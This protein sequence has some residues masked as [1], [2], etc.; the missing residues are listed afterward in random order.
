MKINLVVVV[1]HTGGVGVG[2]DGEGT[3]GV[4]AGAIAEGPLQ[5]PKLVVV[6]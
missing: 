2:A 1:V 6:P 5:F 3:G 4:G